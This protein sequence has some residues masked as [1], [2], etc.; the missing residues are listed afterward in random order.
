MKPI[1]IILDKNGAKIEIKAY[2]MGT[3]P[4]TTDEVINGLPNVSLRPDIYF[5][6]E[7]EQNGQ[8]K[9][10]KIL[11]VADEK[12]VSNNTNFSPSIQDF[13]IKKIKVIKKTINNKY[14]NHP[15]HEA[16]PI[17]IINNSALEEKER[18]KIILPTNS[19]QD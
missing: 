12:S 6:Q 16:K 8:E 2:P 19:F 9:I 5:V 17:T 18:I 4:F 3:G 1:S 11:G 10:I 13:N 7:K 15:N 14:T